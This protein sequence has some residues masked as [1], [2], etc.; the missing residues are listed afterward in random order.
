MFVVSSEVRPNTDSVQTN[1]HHPVR[2]EKGGFLG[3]F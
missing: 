1:A 3:D 2:K